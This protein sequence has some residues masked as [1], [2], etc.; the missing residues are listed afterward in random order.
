MQPI[1]SA[2]EAAET[3]AGRLADARRV[4]ALTGAGASAASG[5]P[6]YRGAGG[7]WTRYDPG[8][9]ASIDYFRK[10][11]SYY[12]RFFRDERYPA[13]SAARPNPVHVAL[14]A[15]ER[16]G[17]LAALVTQNIDGLH[18]EGGSRRVLELHG[19]S[20]RFLCESCG[21]EVAADVVRPLVDEAIPPRCPGC[22]AGT[23]RPDVVLFG[24]ALP[25]AVL[26]EA[27]E[28]MG[29]A[30][31]CLVVGSSL[32]VQPAASLP[33]VAVRAGAALAVLNI[34][35]TPLDP[36]ADLVVR[37]PADLVLPAA[38]AAAGLEG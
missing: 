25:A 30:D 6:T 22:G 26:E 19:N 4:V 15:L 28:A 14:A 21:G 16:A 37:A 23:L 27:F 20:R 31:L 33:L 34:D 7:A 10:D 2:A 35:P 3:L 32:V 29:Q 18:Q 24:E 1:D 5:V 9:Y 11:P 38:L 36:L 13:L 8:K 12:W 17:R